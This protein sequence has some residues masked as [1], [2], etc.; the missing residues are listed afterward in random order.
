M[1][2]CRCGAQIRYGDHIRSRFTGNDYCKDV[3]ACG[4]RLVSAG[5][6]EATRTTRSGGGDG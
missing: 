4:Q 5:V 6:I 1:I 3:R 2:C